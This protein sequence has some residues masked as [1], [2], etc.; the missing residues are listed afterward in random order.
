MS[1]GVKGGSGY[2]RGR[3]VWYGTRR[4]RDDSRR[5]PDAGEPRHR[6][7]GRRLPG[8]RRGLR[9]RRSTSRSRRSRSR[10]RNTKGSTENVPLLEA[11]HARPRAGAGRGRARGAR[12]HRPRAGRPARS[13]A[14]MYLHAGMFVV[15]ADSP[16]RTIAD[17]KGKPVAFGARGSGLVILA[18]YV[19]DGLGL[20]R[21]PRLPGRSTSTAPAT[22]RRWCWT[23]ARPRCGAAAL[24]WPGF[25]AVARGPAGARFIVP[26]ADG[27]RRILAKH[28]FLQPMTRAAGSYPGQTRAISS[29]SARGA[30]SW[31]APR[32]PTTWPTASRAR[33][34]AA[35][36]R[37]PRGS[38]RRARP[39]PPTR[40]PRSPGPELLHPGVRRYLAEIGLT[41]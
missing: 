33:S 20:D 19:L 38:R 8:L 7:A 24:G 12:R 27:I 4:E 2:S 9:R 28:A 29:R 11:G 39:P 6:H 13:L 21:G 5:G 32:W 3:A 41:R 26:D 17:L 16:Y 40:S 35:R 37:S 23:A 30:S 1:G 15:R 34:T 25:T 36:P 14:A 31:R 22:G 10:P 18:R